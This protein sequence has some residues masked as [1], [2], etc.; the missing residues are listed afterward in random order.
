MDSEEHKDS[1]NYTIADEDTT[2]L[3]ESFNNYGKNE[4]ENLFQT[5]YKHFKT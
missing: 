3:Q 1:T 5:K 2:F 4:N